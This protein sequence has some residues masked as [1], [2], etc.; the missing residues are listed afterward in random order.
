MAALQILEYGVGPDFGAVLT[1]R[2]R[3]KLEFKL[4]WSYSLHKLNKNVLL[5]AEN[6]MNLYKITYY[7]YTC[8]L[9]DSTSISGD[10]FLFAPFFIYLDTVLLTQLLSL[11][12]PELKSEK[13]LGS[14]RVC[15]GWY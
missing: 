15:I 9:G 7:V 10:T 2:N 11:K 3:H 4:A 6:S 1:H 12:V 14:E 13:W 8:T 5:F